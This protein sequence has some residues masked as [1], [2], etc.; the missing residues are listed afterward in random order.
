MSYN[1]DDLVDDTHDSSDLGG[2]EVKHAISLQRTEFSL[3]HFAKM[4]GQA[5][6]NAFNK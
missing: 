5:N 4:L 6:Y 1:K 2:G 3:K